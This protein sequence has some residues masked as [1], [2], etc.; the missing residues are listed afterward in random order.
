MCKESKNAKIIYKI[1]RATKKS[2]R[3]DVQVTDAIIKRFENS[4]AI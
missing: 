2:D 4:Q 1:P 3:K